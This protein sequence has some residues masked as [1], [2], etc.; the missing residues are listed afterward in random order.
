MKKNGKVKVI[1]A[2]PEQYEKAM[3]EHDAPLRDSFENLNWQIR[4]QEL[5]AQVEAYENMIQYC[6]DQIA[7]LRAEIDD[8]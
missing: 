2:D 5:K 1:P 3:A 8:A 6:Q 4:K 7:A